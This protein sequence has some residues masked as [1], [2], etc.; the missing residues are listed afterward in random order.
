MPYPD[1]YNDAAFERMWGHHEEEKIDTR[2][3]DE[4]R[5]NREDVTKDMSPF[6]AMLFNCFRSSNP[7]EQIKALSELE[8]TITQEKDE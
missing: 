6:G 8:N 1:N 5:E 7:D 3:E 4:I 2:N